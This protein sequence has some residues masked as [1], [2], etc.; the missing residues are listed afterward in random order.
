MLQSIKR[1]KIATKVNGKKITT[2]ANG[3]RIT[4]N[5]ENGKQVLIY[6]KSKLEKELDQ[7]AYD[8][9]RHHLESRRAM[10][11]VI[12]YARKAGEALIAAKKALGVGLKNRK[13]RDERR[14]VFGE[15]RGRFGRWLCEH[16]SGSVETARLY[17][18]IAVNWNA[19][20]IVHART[21]GVK[22]TSINQFTGLLKK[23]VDPLEEGSPKKK[24]GAEVNAEVDAEVTKLILANVKMELDTLDTEDVQVIYH[25]FDTVW[26]LV[27]KK[28]HQ[29]RKQP[30]VKK[31]TRPGSR[32]VNGKTSNKKP[33]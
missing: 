6:G 7:L 18:R 19:P 20:A 32:S 28:I 3:R 29:L 2:T 33:K 1:K 30:K 12:D 9:N 14:K 5:Q 16:F 31:S 27:V 24:P 26:E 17:M 11:E 4:A 22:I 13:E 8:A 21:A 10:E 15:T 25:E 23:E